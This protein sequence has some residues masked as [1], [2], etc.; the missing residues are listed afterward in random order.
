VG[1]IA[2]PLVLLALPTVNLLLDPASFRTR[3]IDDWV[4][5][6]G[7]AVALLWIVYA[8]WPSAFRL[9][10]GGPREIRIDNGSLILGSGERQNLR[11][12]SAIEILRPWL[13]HPRVALRFPSGCVVI[14]TAYQT[15][16]ERRSVEDIAKSLADAA[17]R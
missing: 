16:G 15:L 13:Q 4:S 3:W 6:V 10:S 1:A 9:L 17:R 7:I 8:L 11:D 14:E 2:F 5:T 12:L